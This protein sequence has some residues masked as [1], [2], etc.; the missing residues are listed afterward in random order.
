MIEDKKNNKNNKKFTLILSI[1][2]IIIAIAVFVFLAIKEGWFDKD[3]IADKNRQNSITYDE[4]G[5]VVIK[6]LIMLQNN[7]FDPQIID[8]KVGELV[9][10]QNNNRGPLKII[11]DGW[12]TPYLDQGAVFT[13]NDFKEGQNNFYLEGAP[14]NIGIVNMR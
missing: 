4:N 2:C 13:K 6:N 9:V 7:S 5:N 11:G 12:Q 1:V 10:F 3:K 8:A 14:M